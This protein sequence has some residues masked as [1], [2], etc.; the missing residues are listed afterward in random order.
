MSIQQRELI[1][2]YRKLFPQATESDKTVTLTIKGISITFDKPL[3]GATAQS[4]RNISYG[5]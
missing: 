2:I 5:S 4:K 1:E 3:K